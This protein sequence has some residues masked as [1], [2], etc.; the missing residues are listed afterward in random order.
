MSR[1][2]H[3]DGQILSRYARDHRENSHFRRVPLENLEGVISRWCQGG[4]NLL[5]S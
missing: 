3:F 5:E 2:P 1:D 4:Q